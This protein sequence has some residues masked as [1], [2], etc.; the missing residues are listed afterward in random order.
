M[1]IKNKYISP[2]LI[3]GLCV[4]VL[5]E[6]HQ[7]LKS[8]P[9]YVN[10]QDLFRMPY[11]KGCKL[12]LE[13]SQVATDSCQLKVIYGNDNTLYNWLCNK[14]HLLEDKQPIWTAWHQLIK[15]IETMDQESTTPAKRPLQHLLLWII[16]EII[17]IQ[18]QLEQFCKCKCQTQ[19]KDKHTLLIQPCFICWSM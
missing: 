1:W 5:P 7:L 8:Y 14:I 2:S 10:F 6:G 11:K 3:A 17:C 13:Q 15:Y 16:K 4:L 12:L 19:A 9:G 18:L